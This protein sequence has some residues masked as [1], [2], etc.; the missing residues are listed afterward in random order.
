M[1]TTQHT[2]VKGGLKLGFGQVVSQVCSF[3]RSII[4]ARLISPAN[5]GIAATF[6]MTFSLLE[7]LSNLSA[8]KLLIQ[9]KDGNH[10]ELQSTA[11]LL[12]LMRGSV[13]AA[14]IFALAIP[15]ARLFGVPQAAW[16]FECLALVPLI[17]GSAH[18]DSNRLQREIR[19]GPSV[20]ID[21]ATNVVATLAAFPLGWWLRDYSAMLWL[22]V[23][24][25]IGYSIGSHLVAERRYA[26]SWHPEYVKKMAAFGWPLLIN[27]VL[28]FGIFEGDRLVIG[29]SHRLFA[30]SI[31]TLTDL[32]VYSVAFSI[33][34]APTMFVGNVCNSLFLP[35]LSQVQGSVTQFNR[36]YSACA[37]MIALLAAAISIPFIIA[38]GKGVILI[39]GAKYSGAS[40]VIGWLAAMWA[41][42]MIRVTPTLAA[43]ARGDTRNAMIS[44]LVRSTALAGI[45]CAAALG[46]HLFWISICG[47]LGEVMA[48]GVSILRLRVRS[49]VPVLLCVRP[50]FIAGAA[51]ITAGLTS[52][53]AAKAWLPAISSSALLVGLTVVAMLAAFPR[54]RQD[55]QLIVLRSGLRGGYRESGEGLAL[56]L[57]GGSSGLDSG[58]RMVGTAGRGVRQSHA[59]YET[60]AQRES[61]TSRSPVVAGAR[62]EI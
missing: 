36:R 7:M 44:N 31:Y 2:V 26:L 8:D 48:T 43:M 15:I 11:Q 59:V 52:S 28:M 9:S 47:F 18:L 22:L 42:R 62:D 16:A 51:M 46:S 50:L 37:E 39:Y 25:A 24:Q 19:F 49:G 32:G 41:L 1:S 57:S 27:G 21:I 61:A 23:L 10:P 13:N 4:L 17:R 12:D 34:M 45:L 55:L 56:P 53:F 60:D 6:A 38:G 33:T 30:R 3:I 35:L 54:L 5:F 14:I 40:A 20:K 58:E 29:A